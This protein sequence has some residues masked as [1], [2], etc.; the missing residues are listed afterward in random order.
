VVPLFLPAVQAVQAVAEAAV[1]AWLLAPTTIRLAV[2]LQINV[3]VTL[4]TQVDW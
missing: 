2:V 1:V 4:H 3:A